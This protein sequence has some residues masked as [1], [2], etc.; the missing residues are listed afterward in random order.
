MRRTLYDTSERVE[1]AT[2][3]R[4]FVPVLLWRIR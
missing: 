3:L 2:T 4:L 1:A